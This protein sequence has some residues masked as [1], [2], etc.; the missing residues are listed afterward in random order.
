[1]PC[2]TDPRSVAAHEADLSISSSA[3]LCLVLPSSCLSLI[4]S[5]L[6]L[7]PVKPATAP[8]TAP[9]T[10]SPTPLP[11]SESCPFASWPWPW[12]FCSRPSRFR[13]SLPKRLPTVSLP[14]P[15]V[16]SH[17]PWVRSGSSFV[18]APEEPMVKGPALTADSEAVCSASALARVWLALA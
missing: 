13:L 12:R 4:S 7:S 8:P 3:P 17:A 6:L 10:R 2:I 9:F 16:W 18:A 14:E 15:R 1:M 11:R 5:C